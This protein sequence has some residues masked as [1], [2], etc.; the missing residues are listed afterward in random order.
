MTFFFLECNETIEH[1]IRKPAPWD[2]AASGPPYLCQGQLLLLALVS[3]FGRLQSEPVSDLKSAPLVN[4][5]LFKHGS[6]RLDVSHV[7]VF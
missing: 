3:Y 7:K 2:G 5:A 1:C 4:R 6:A